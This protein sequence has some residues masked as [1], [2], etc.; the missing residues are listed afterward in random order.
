M[1]VEKACAGIGGDHWRW[2][3]GGRMV[4]RLVFLVDPGG[5]G[6]AHNPAC[7]GD[8]GTALRPRV[9]RA[10]LA[11]DDHQLAEE[12]TPDDHTQFRRLAAVIWQDL[13]SLPRPRETFQGP[14]L[15]DVLGITDERTIRARVQEGRWLWRNWRR[16]RGHCGPTGSLRCVGTVTVLMLRRRQPSSPGAKG[17]PFPRLTY[18]SVGPSLTT[19]SSAGSRP[20]AVS[21]FRRTS[22]SVSALIR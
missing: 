15:G 12:L 2:R 13:G 17:K 16:G 21:N 18:G 10:F 14:S 3:Y 4:P 20:M 19:F 22:P 7:R 8:R 1:A 6:L 5:D 9:R 11:P